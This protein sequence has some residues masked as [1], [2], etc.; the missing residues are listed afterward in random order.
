MSDEHNVFRY[1]SIYCKRFLAFTLNENNVF[2]YDSI[3]C[4]NFPHLRSINIMYFV[5]I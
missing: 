3:Y 5:M 1:D 2:R 4:K